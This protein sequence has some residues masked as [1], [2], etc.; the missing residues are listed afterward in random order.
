VPDAAVDPVVAERTFMAEVVR[1]LATLRG[2]EPDEPL[3]P[4]DLAIPLGLSAWIVR[5]SVDLPDAFDALLRL[6]AEVLA[7][8]GL[9]RASEPVPLRVGD[10]RA[11]LRSL[12]SYLFDLV[13]RAARHARLSP[14]ELAERTLEQLECA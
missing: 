5:A 3:P 8:S 14:V 10:P 2:D 7:V 9:D 4:G 6:R 12:G 13:G 1:G 11:A